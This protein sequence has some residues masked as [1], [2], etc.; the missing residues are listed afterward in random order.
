MIS[1]KN[2]SIEEKLFVL[3]FSRT[4]T[5][6]QISELT[7]ISEGIISEL[8]SGKRKIDN[9]RLKSARNLED[10]YDEL[11][12]KGQINYNRDFKKAKQHFDKLKG[13]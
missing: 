6:Y 12:Q 11:E 2:I 3:L 9:L 7:G 1:L 10:C 4:I 13:D 8:R 5:G